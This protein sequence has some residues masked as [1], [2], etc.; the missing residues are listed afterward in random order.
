MGNRSHIQLRATRYATEQRILR[1]S[2][3]AP[4]YNEQM[5]MKAGQGLIGKVPS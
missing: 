5:R 3:D 4:W 2:L 1:T